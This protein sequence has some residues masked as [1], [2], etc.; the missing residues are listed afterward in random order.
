[1]PLIYGTA[2]SLRTSQASLRADIAL[3]T[4]G[5]HLERVRDSLAKIGYRVKGL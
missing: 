5:K 4:Q 2:V 3:E 1:M